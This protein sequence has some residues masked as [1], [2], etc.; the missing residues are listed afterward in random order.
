M[1]RPTE[2]MTQSPPGKSVRVA[3]GSSDPVSVSLAEARAI[4]LRSQGLADE[5]APF[6][7][8]KSAVLAA[9]EHLGYVQ[10]DTV[11]V[12]QRAHHHVIWSRVPDYQPE[13]LHELQSPD[14]AV[15]E[16]WNH[17]S[18]YLPTKDYRFSLPLMRSHR[19]ELHWFDDT[20]ELR[21]SMRRMRSLIRKRGPLM[22]SDVESKA[23]VQ[24]WGEQS[25][26]KIERRALHELWMQ[27]EIMIRSRKGF[28]KVFD[29]SHRVL[30]A[31][32]EL[33]FP[34]KRESAEFHVRRALRALGVARI[35]E[36]HY[37]QDA[38][39]ADLVKN[40]LSGLIKSGEVLECRV[41]EFPNVAV[42]VLK[43][44]LDL[45]GPLK[46]SVM[47]F[48]SPFDNLTI[49][50]KR[51]KWLFHFDYSVEIY[52][53]AQKRKYG[54]FALPILWG[55]RVIG[56]LD[57][58]A[59]RPERRLVVNNLVFEPNIAVTEPVQAALLEALRDFTRFQ[60][61]DEWEILRVEPKSFRRL[62]KKSSSTLRATH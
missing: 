2:H 9:I 45:A 40:G 59:Y 34:G 53:P 55:D 32:T 37:L 48:L 19:S 57:A 31:R 41:D 8:G 11:S 58:K 12:I 54:Y 39:R 13:M 33:D 49:Q 47:R 28:Q 1:M 22:I 7:S 18:S 14:A 16:Y 56:R 29:L 23:R 38:D 35:Q 17:A 3:A 60:N 36:L 24:Q 4:S 20:P 61:C 6:G 21:A 30:P 52:V 15:F 44:A 46:E 10:V 42:F 51:L 25:L 27:G 43:E 26:G 5:T 50:R 62:L